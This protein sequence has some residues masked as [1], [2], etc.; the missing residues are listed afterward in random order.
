[1]ERPRQFEARSTHP[2]I[3]RTRAP[4]SEGSQRRAPSP[5]DAQTCASHE[6]QAYSSCSSHAS[7]SPAR[8]LPP[9]AAA[10]GLTAS[11]APPRSE[12]RAAARPRKLPRNAARARPGLHVRP[13]H[14]HIDGEAVPLERLAEVLARAIVLEHPFLEQRPAHPE[15]PGGRRLFGHRPHA[16]LEECAWAREEGVTQRNRPRPEAISDRHPPGSLPRRATARTRNPCARPIGSCPAGGSRA[17]LTL[18]TS[19]SIVA[20]AWYSGTW[21]ARPRCP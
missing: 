13:R 5:Q 8:A 6:R 7:T 4:R 18:F 21:V 9:L 3:C 20:H 12:G 16:S 17:E 10:P 19:A 1:M 11:A 14:A 2:P 15:R